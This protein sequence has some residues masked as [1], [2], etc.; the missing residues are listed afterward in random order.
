MGQLYATSCQLD[1]GSGLPPEGQGC[2]F[3][4]EENSLQATA[5]MWQIKWGVDGRE[6]RLTE[7]CRKLDEITACLLLGMTK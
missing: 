6:V 5:Q 2:F 1:I 4:A 3:L 7:F